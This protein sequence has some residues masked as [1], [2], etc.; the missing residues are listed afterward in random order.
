MEKIR[1]RRKAK[2][3]KP[4]FPKLRAKYGANRSY[5]FS[6]RAWF[7]FKLYAIIFVLLIA[8]AAVAF[9]V[10]AKD[11]QP[12]NVADKFFD[13]A[14]GVTKYEKSEA[15]KE[16]DAAEKNSNSQAP[17]RMIGANDI[18]LLEDSADPCTHVWVKIDE[19][20]GVSPTC[21]T[22]GTKI[23][24]RKCSLCAL[25]E[26]DTIILPPTGDH[27]PSEAV[28]EYEE[29]PNCL[30]EYN[31]DYV[32]YCTD[33]NA[34][35]SRETHT[36]NLGG[37]QFEY[38]EEN[39]VHP[40]C[41]DAGSYDK[42][43]YCTVCG[44]VD[45]ENVKPMTIPATGHSY[46]VCTDDK[47]AN[48][49]CDATRD[50]LT[51]TEK[52][53]ETERK[54]PTCTESGSVTYKAVCSVCNTD[55]NKTKTEPLK[56]TGHD[57]PEATCTEA[58]VCKTCGKELAK[59]T[60]HDVKLCSELTE[61]EREAEDASKCKKCGVAFN[62]HTDADKNYKCDVE[63]CEAK[64]RTINF[65]AVIYI[66]CLI[67][68][69]ILAVWFFILTIILFVTICKVSTMHLEFYDEVVVWRWGRFC[70][71]HVEQ[72]FVGVYDVLVMPRNKLNYNEK[73]EAKRPAKFGTVLAKVPGGDYEWNRKF[74]GVKNPYELANFLKGKK[75]AER[76]K[77]ARTNFHDNAT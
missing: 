37:H 43:P 19:E 77:C 25:E 54:N 31:Y 15:T 55:L 35:L 22:T 50:P 24:T 20:P 30:K 29:T 42:V 53:V 3:E 32:V 11:F 58:S 38:R 48:A 41:T 26:E 21:S 67:A 46:P 65:K 8:V 75:I 7:N 49:D 70:K 13:Y 66:L 9:V 51:H 5:R 28:K 12:D 40:T 1:T 64:L 63:G 56:A 52:Y 60:G 76:H 14:P 36:V 6:L 69:P 34:E 68:T 62:I 74:F 16:A 57:A 39:V 17:V 59:A 23:I 73:R 71:H 4:Q 33:C 18:V 72:R 47:C 45:V 10:L 61:K 44:F 27:K 2:A